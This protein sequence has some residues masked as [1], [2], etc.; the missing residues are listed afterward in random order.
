MSG[1]EGAAGSGSAFRW[2][3]RVASRTL[4]GT[5]FV[6]L[7]SR[8]LR[9]NEVGT[10]IWERFE[11]GATVQ[12][13]AAAVVDEFETTLAQAAPDIQELVAELV[14]KDMLISA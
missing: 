11:H 7:N 13:V 3:P 9:L 8:M 5:A 6:L 14:R 1:V 4:K 12:E 10:R 2:N